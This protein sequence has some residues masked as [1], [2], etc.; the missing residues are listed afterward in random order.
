MCCRYALSGPTSHCNASPDH[1]VYRVE[2][3]DFAADAI[4]TTEKDAVKFP[5]LP[6]PVWVL[7]VTAQVDPDLARFVLEN[8]D[9][10]PSA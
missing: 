10:R 3:L 1:H 7:P 2:D 6:L 8:L 4:M 9:G 5:E